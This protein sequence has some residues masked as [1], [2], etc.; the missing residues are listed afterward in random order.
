MSLI[1]V[2]S[3]L[4]T[5]SYRNDYFD[6]KKKKNVL[7]FKYLYKGKLQQICIPPHDNIVVGVKELVQKAIPNLVKKKTVK[8]TR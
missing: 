7:T 3:L 4:C 1:K 5:L 2:G 6:A 8:N